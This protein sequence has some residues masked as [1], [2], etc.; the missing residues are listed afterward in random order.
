M[1]LRPALMFQDGMILQRNRQIP[2]WGTAAPCASVTLAMQGKSFDSFADAKGNWMILCGP[3]DVSVSE[4]VV[5]SSGDEMITLSDVMV[6]DVYLAGGQSNMEFHMR[7]DA[8]MAEE[9]AGGGNPLI[10]LFDYPRVSYAEQIHQADYGK[11]YGFWRRCTPENL[12]RFPAVAYYFAKELT[13]KYQVPV[14]I[15]GCN[16]GATRACAWMPEDEIRAC[17]GQPWLDDYARETE[18]LDPAVYDRR[19][20]EN[21]GSW[22]TDLLASPITDLMMFGC[23]QAELEQKMMEMGVDL[24]QI[25]IA[26]MLP[27]MGPKHENRPSGLYHAMLEQLAPYGLR[28]FLW[29]QGEADA[30]AHPEVY[31]TLFPGLIRSWRKLW[32]DDTLPFLFVQLA[33]LEEMFGNPATNFPVI[34]AAQQH[35]AD[36]VPFTG[37]AVTTDIGMQHDIHPKEKKPI[38]QRLALLAERLIYEENVL[39]EAPVLQECQTENGRVVLRFA[40]AG[41]GLAIKGTCVNGLR[42]Y[43]G[44]TELHVQEMRA[45]VQGDLLILYADA[46]R[47]GMLLHPAIAMTPWHQVNLYNSA[48]IPVR[49]C[50]L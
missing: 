22:K 26:D 11:Q 2:V 39:C 30:D 49:P 13:R 21:P 43:D 44:K 6:G 50:E 9:A 17:G 18:K 3:F 10:R 20:M 38:G 23:T 34:R 37:M 45:E 15:L 12:E 4:E 40:N 16:W 27:P 28:G 48:G 31:Q 41:E 29:Y 35:A 5:L 14:G 46:F 8:N 32:Q 24:S 47:K 33:P 36:T 1:K 42:L 7:Y 19:F 25:S